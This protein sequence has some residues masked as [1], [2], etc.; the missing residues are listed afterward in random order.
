[1]TPLP[2]DLTKE[3]AEWTPEQIHWIIEHGVKMSGMP[4]FG[5]SYGSQSTWNIAGFVEQSPTMSAEIYASIPRE[6]AGHHGS[7]ERTKDR[8]SPMPLALKNAY[9]G[10]SFGNL[11]LR[12]SF[13]SCA[14][15]G[16]R[17]AGP[18]ASG[19]LPRRPFFSMSASSIFISVISLTWSR[20]MR[21]AR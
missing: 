3:A 7:G 13:A 11:P 14:P 19:A 16:L 1:M 12:R 4:M 10:S 2:P 15:S 6:G 20:V 8:A 18:A 21:S 17:A 5:G 9:S